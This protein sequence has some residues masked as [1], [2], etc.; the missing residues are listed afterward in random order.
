MFAS[1]GPVLPATSGAKNALLS[2]PV[3]DFMEQPCSPPP[4]DLSTIYPCPGVAIPMPVAEMSPHMAS[5]DLYVSP[6]N[7]LFDFP[8]ASHQLP[9]RAYHLTD[10]T[11]HPISGRNPLSQVAP[12]AQFLL[13]PVNWNGRELQCEY[14]FMLSASRESDQATALACSFPPAFNCDSD[15]PESCTMEFD[16]QSSS[17]SSKSGI[18]SPDLYLGYKS[19]GEILASLVKRLFIGL[20]TTPRYRGLRNQDARRAQAHSTAFTGFG[21][22]WTQSLPSVEEYL[23][24]AERKDTTNSVGRLVLTVDNLEELNSDDEPDSLYD[25]FGSDSDGCATLPFI[26]AP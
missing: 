9:A 13:S 18:E 20:P 5:Q 19:E 3:S 22:S 1:T 7:V 11:N 10:A 14:R 25:G 8:S 6:P 4:P 21:G 2:V 12:A 24:T 23:E 17:P 16:E 26:S 15:S